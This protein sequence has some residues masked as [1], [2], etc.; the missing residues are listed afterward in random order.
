MKGEARAGGIYEVQ[1]S[2]MTHTCLNGDER[3]DEHCDLHILYDKIPS[4]G[5]F[6]LLV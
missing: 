4:V 2:F 1:K 6:S 5:F 3:R